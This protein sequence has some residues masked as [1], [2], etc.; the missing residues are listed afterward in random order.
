MSN[1]HSVSRF[2]DLLRYNYCSL[3]FMSV[4]EICND[5]PSTFFFD[6]PI[7]SAFFRTLAV[8][9][10]FCSFIFD[11]LAFS[12]PS[13][14]LIYFL[15]DLSERIPVSGT[16]SRLQSSLLRMKGTLL[17]E[18]FAGLGKNGRQKEYSSS[19]VPGIPL[20]KIPYGSRAQALE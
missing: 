12:V 3:K 5:I 11:I 4:S 19:L 20:G 18:F 13:L 7:F 6:S 1:P 15:F 16:H 10:C 9:H 2:F 14:V 17:V 8:V